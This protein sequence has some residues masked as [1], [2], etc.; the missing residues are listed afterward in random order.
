MFLNHRIKNTKQKQR[1]WKRRF[2]FTASQV[3]ERGLEFMQSGWELHCIV[4]LHGL[5]RI[6]GG[7]W[8]GGLGPE[9]PAP[10]LSLS[11]LDRF[12]GPF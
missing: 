9:G 2:P 11:A 6:G 1:I 12:C 7:V 8:G 10:F 4:P 3:M 5:R